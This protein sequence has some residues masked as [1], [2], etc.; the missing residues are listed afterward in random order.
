MHVNDQALRLHSPEHEDAR[1]ALATAYVRPH[2]LEVQRYR[3]GESG[4]A[5]KL[6]RA[7]VVGPTARL[8]LEVITQE[9][10]S[11][12]PQIV[13]AQIPAGQFHAQGF[14]EGDALLLTPRKARVFVTE[15]VRAS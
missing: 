10:N 4:I 2:D 7:I 12:S 6:L 8:E 1:H 11:T 5:A 9:K 14:N 3:A 13:E 15:S